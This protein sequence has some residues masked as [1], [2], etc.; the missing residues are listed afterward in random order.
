MGY[1]EGLQNIKTEHTNMIL[2]KASISKKSNF[3]DLIK[4]IQES[5]HGN[6]K[7]TF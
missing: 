6:E 4:L 7:I 5:L 2:K 1:L 3:Y